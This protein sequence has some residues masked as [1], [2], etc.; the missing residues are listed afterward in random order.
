M[1][2]FPTDALELAQLSMVSV[3]ET[4]TI[5]DVEYRAVTLSGPGI[6]GSYQPELVRRP[7]V[8]A[9]F[10][11]GSIGEEVPVDF[12][13]FGRPSSDETVDQVAFQQEQHAFMREL[14]VKATVDTEALERFESDGQA[15]LHRV[16]SQTYGHELQERLE[17]TCEVY[18]VPFSMVVASEIVRDGVIVP[19]ERRAT[20][21]FI[22]G[23]SINAALE[24]LRTP[25]LIMCA[26]NN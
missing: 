5:H 21:F 7:L 17:T 20:L 13:I 22:G 2:D 24:A 23:A 10:W 6:V 8:A 16:L 12:V 15:N 1:A 18:K 4:K 19:G 26:D 11:P 9:G 14:L 3:C 25:T